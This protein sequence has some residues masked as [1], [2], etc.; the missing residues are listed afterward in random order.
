MCLNADIVGAAI[1]RSQLRLP[2]RYTQAEMKPSPLADRK[3]DCPYFPCGRGKRSLPI[4]KIH[5]RIIAQKQP[6]TGSVRQRRDYYRTLRF[7]N[8]L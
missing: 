2:R 7:E 3:R 4:P 8:A 1:E 5:P 6:K